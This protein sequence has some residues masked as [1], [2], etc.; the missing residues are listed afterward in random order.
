MAGGEDERAARA[1]DGEAQR[2][3]DLARLD[4]VV[5]REAGEDRQAGGVGAR[6]AARAQRVRA[7]VEDRA[8]A[9]ASSA[10]PLRCAANS[11][12]SRHVP[13]WTS[14]MWRSPPPS[15]LGL[16]RDRVRAL[17][18]LVRVLEAHAGA[19]LR[20]ARRPGTGCRS[21]GPR[22][23]R[24]RSPD[25]RS[26][27]ARSRAPSRPSAGARGSAS[28]RWFHG[29]LAGKTGS[30]RSRPRRAGEHATYPGTPSCA[31]SS[32]AE[33]ATSGRSS[34]SSCVARGDDVTVLDSLYRGHRA[35]VPEG[36]AF[37]EADLLD[38]DGARRGARRRLRRRPA[39][40]GAVAGRRVRRAPRAL[41]PRQRRRRR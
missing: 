18:G 34:P 14:S 29:L 27:R 17:V 10:L 1:L 40:R 2:V 22:S 6:P 28:T 19:L 23:G 4:L 20:R 7:Q 24:S 9:G 15:I 41:L 11:S 39:L 32:P 26:R 30:R 36:A 21:G 12:K 31:C 38:A 8:A 35:A 33:P 25:G 5:A 16:G 3:A 37:V 13:R